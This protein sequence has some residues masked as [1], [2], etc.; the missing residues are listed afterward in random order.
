MTGSALT[1]LEGSTFCISDEVGDIGEET[2]G[3]F[4]QD[5]RF[6]SAATINHLSIHWRTKALAHR[7][8]SHSR[9]PQP[10]ARPSTRVSELHLPT[11]PVTLDQTITC[12]GS[13]FAMPCTR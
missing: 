6:L 5:T 9:R 3:F 11:R 8:H 1:I 13:I 12:S 2:S 7:Q 4:A 10:S